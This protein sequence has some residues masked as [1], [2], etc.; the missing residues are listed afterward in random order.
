MVEQGKFIDVKGIR[1]HYNEAGQ[2]EPLLLIHGS[3]PGVSAWANWRLAFPTLSEYYHLY[4]PDVVGFGYTERLE[5]QEYSIDVWVNH[6]IDFIETIGESRV[7]VIGNSFGGAIALHL[8][9]R[10]PDLVNKLIL[11]GSVG[12]DSPLSEG[13]DAVWGYIPGFENM[14]KLVKIFAYDQSMA[15]ND[16][17]VEMRYQSS[18]QEGFQEAFS[19]MFPAPR[20]RHLD[21][22]A[23]SIDE[24]KNIRVP[25]LLIHGREDKVIPVEETS[26]KLAKIIPNASLHIFPQCGHWVQ[27]EKTEPFLTQVIEFLNRSKAANL[28]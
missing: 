23:L 11:M 4:A 7:S 15:E 2:G 26:W 3:G 16:D 17:L 6:M 14:K 20:Q 12:I 27:I 13:L 10:R 24:L 25:V 21:A 18:I 19:S 8:V 9:N 1:T 22:M 5:N 28:V